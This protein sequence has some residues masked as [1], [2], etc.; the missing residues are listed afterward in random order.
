MVAMFCFAVP[1]N[2]DVICSS[3]CRALYRCNSA[4]QNNF[5]YTRSNRDCDVSKGF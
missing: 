5:V 1:A 2:V 4:W 3:Y